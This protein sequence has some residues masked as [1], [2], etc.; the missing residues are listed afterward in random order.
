MYYGTRLPAF[1]SKLC[2][3]PVGDAGQVTN[4]SVPQFPHLS[5]VDD[6]SAKFKEYNEL[7]FVKCVEQCLTKGK[8]NLGLLFRRQLKGEEIEVADTLCREA[9]SRGRE[10]MGPHLQEEEDSS[11]RAQGL[12]SILFPKIRESVNT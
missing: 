12:G 10:E 7:I 6:N 2:Q 11:D 1:E 9:G 5:S 8:Y 3:L 4:L